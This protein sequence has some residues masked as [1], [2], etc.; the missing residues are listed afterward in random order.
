MKVSHVCAVERLGEGPAGQYRIKEL[1]SNGGSRNRLGEMFTQKGVY[2]R[3]I[4]M[5]RGDQ[6]DVMTKRLLSC[7]QAGDHP[8]RTSIGGVEPVIDVDDAQ[9]AIH[10]VRALTKIAPRDAM[11]HRP[12]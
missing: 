7:D 1:G 12:T 10:G 9:G 11:S 6:T 8:R 2:R 3:R 5:I 4:G